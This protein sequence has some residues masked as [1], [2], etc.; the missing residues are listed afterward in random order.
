VRARTF[1]YR[2]ANRAEFRES[3]QRWVRM[4]LYEAIP[5]LSLPSS[6]K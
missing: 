2:F 4:E 3:G 5:P 1:L 6:P